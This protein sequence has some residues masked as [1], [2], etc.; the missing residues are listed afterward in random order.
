MSKIIALFLFV[1]ISSASFPQE[2]E[3]FRGGM[4]LHTGY[5]KNNLNFPNVDGLIYGIGG[6]ISFRFGEHLRIGTE[7][8][9]S[10]FNYKTNEGNYKIGW[11]G[12]LTE[13]QFTNKKLNPVA[14]ISFG[15][16]KVHDLFVLSGDF[17]DNF[18]DQTIYKVY[19]TFILSPHFSL[20]YTV[21]ES[22][23]LVLK[24]DYQFYP[25]IQFPDYISKGA[26]FYFGVLFMR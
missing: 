17:E 16:G 24:A 25:G 13:Y 21:T 11:G 6:K 15:A 3:L 26:R 19:P 12:L 7:G 4:F 9:V 1:L 23:N 8:Y 22:I 14:G 20:E 2:R 5:Q 10:T 18:I